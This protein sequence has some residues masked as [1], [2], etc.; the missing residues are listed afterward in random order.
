MWEENT[1]SE[2]C[3]LLPEVLQ[4]LPNQL[5]GLLAHDTEYSLCPAP[6]FGNMGTIAFIAVVSPLHAESSNTFFGRWSQIKKISIDWSRSPASLMT[7]VSSDS[8]NS[9]H[10]SG[11]HMQQRVQQ[12]SSPCLFYTLGETQ[13][14]S[15]SCWNFCLPLLPLTGPWF[16]PAPWHVHREEVVVI[17]FGFVKLIL[18]NTTPLSL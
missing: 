13:E 15:S 5:S 17:Q 16:K 14:V 2:C 1:M 8:G 6:C 7:S 3:L 10:A 12:G 9:M 11:A 4:D 18:R